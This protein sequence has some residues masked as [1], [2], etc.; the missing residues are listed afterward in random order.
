VTAAFTPLAADVKRDRWGRPLIVP[1]EGGKPE[2][3]TRVSTIAKVLDDKTALMRWKQRMT[4]M[5][6]GL[7]PDLAQLAAVVGDD[8]RKLDEIVEQAMA[9]A[10]TSR[11]ANVGTTL[12]KLTEHVDAGTLPA[13]LPGETIADLTAYEEAMRGIEILAS[14]AFVVIDELKA[15]GTFDRLV[16]VPDG[17]LMVGDL[18]TGQNEPNYPHSAATQVSMYSRGHLYDPERG[19]LGHLPSLGVDQDHGLLIHLP[20]GSGKCALYLL[21]LRVGWSMAQTAVLVREVFRGKPITPLT[22]TT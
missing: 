18:K 22:L 11:A 9:A 21:D 17:R 5:G 3:Y 2:A 12:H 19:R 16:R 14:E 6:I 4:T 20:A 7:R 15:A 8:K 10:D 1:P 13:H